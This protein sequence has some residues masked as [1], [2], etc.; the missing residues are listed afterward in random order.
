MERLLK[1]NIWAICGDVTNEDKFAFRI[2]QCLKGQNY[3]VYPFMD[4]E[5]EGIYNDFTKMPKL[6]DVLVLCTS[7]NRG[8]DAV[9]KAKE[10]GIKRV[11]AQ[12]GARSEKIEKYCL[13]HDL[14]Y[15]EDCVI[16]ALCCKN[17]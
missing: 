15:I 9:K 14:I 1:C 3:E 10:A 2:V 11:L 12:P 13:K 17:T 4:I 7:P 5:K 8:L 16:T 6:P